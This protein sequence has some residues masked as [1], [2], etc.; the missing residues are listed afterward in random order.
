MHTI[1][2][3]L[4]VKALIEYDTL[5]PSNYLV[6]VIFTWTARPEFLM[7]FNVCDIISMKRM[8]RR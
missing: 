5:P 2:H 7:L 4:G 3:I 1:V 6:F 8:T